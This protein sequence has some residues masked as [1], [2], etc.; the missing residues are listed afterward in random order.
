ME[1]F[2]RLNFFFCSNPPSRPSFGEQLVIMF[3]HFHLIIHY[4]VRQKYQSAMR[5]AYFTITA[6]IPSAIFGLA[7]FYCDTF[8][9]KNQCSR[10]GDRACRMRT[11]LLSH[12]VLPARSFI[13]SWK[14]VT[15]SFH[16]VKQ[17]ILGLAT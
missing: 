16:R 15:S 2:A 1:S 7:W 11:A 10:Y 5:L 4:R 9:V 13:S 6:F 12:Q 17:P 3:D 14:K 8:D